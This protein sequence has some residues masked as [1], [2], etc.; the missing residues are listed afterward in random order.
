MILLI[1]GYNIDEVGL[2]VEGLNLRVKD[3]FK[4]VIRPHIMC[5]KNE[6]VYSF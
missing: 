2:I 4:I 6:I 5:W 1:S 3:T